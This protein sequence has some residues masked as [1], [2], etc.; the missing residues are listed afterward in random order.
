MSRPRARGDRGPRPPPGR[1]DPGILRSAP[2]DETFDILRGDPGVPPGGLAL[3]LIV[4]AL[5]GTSGAARRELVVGPATRRAAFAG[6]WELNPATAGGTGWPRAREAPSPAASCS[7]GPWLARAPGCA[8]SCWSC[9]G[10][11]PRRIA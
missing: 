3:V 10:P 9:A 6:L 7:A 5:P 4:L 8:T 2:G 11:H 1:G